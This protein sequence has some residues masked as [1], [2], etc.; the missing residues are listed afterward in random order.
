M[1]FNYISFSDSANQKILFL[2][3]DSPSNFL[4]QK[5]V[6]VMCFVPKR[7]NDMMN[8]GRLQ[9][10]E[11]RHTFFIHLSSQMKYMSSVT[12]GLWQ[13]LHCVS[14]K[15]HGSGEAAPAGHLFCQRAG[16]RPPVQSQGEAGLPV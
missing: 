7:C 12:Y 10:F 16:R 6:E 15:N 5:A 3:P 4:H 11:V 1:E 14:G 8:V 13:C 9:G 2:V